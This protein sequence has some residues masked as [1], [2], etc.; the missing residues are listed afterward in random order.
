K[1]LYA[2]YFL[3]TMK[4]K[5]VSKAQKFP[6]DIALNT[7]LKSHSL[8]DFDS[9]YTAPVHGYKNAYDYWTKASSKPDLHC[10]TTATLIINARN[11]PLVPAWSL[12]KREHCSSQITLVQPQQGGHAGFVTGEFPGHRQ[13]LSE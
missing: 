11:D 1:H 10:I 7:L 3:K 2:R 4:R 5:M 13:W 8:E 12:P 6:N 9:H